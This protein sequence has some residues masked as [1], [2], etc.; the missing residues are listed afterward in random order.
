MKTARVLVLAL[1]CGLC[2]AFAAGCGS[3]SGGGGADDPAAVVPAGAV[4]YAEATIHPEGKVRADAEAA[5]RKILKTDDPAA[6]ITKA[7]ESASKG[8]GDL[9]FKDDVEPWL[10]DRVGA[11]VTSL[12]STNDADYVIV[13]ASKDDGKA[14][15]ALAKQK[16]DIVKRAYKGVDYRF[17]AKENTAA[18]VVNHRVVI[19]TEGGM[20]SAID[21]SKGDSLAEANGLRDVRAKVAP[22]RIGLFYLDVQGLLRTVA[23]S[24]SK[25]PALGAILQSA[26]GAAPRT[27]GGALQAQPDQ[28][29]VDAV[30]LATPKSSTTGG[31]G[32][33]VLAGLPADSWA[34]LGVANIGQTLDRIVQTIANTGGLTSVGVNA[35]LQQFQEKT[36]LDLRKD[37]LSW[38]GDAGVYVAGTTAH[39]LRGALVVKTT[40]AAKTRRTIAALERLARGSSGVHIRPLSGAGIDDG[41][42]IRQKSGPA[43][44]VALASDKLVVA[45]GPKRVIAEAAAPAQKLGSAPAF[46][47]AAAKLGG[48]L[49]PSFF[50][51]FPQ[52]VGLI[53]GFVGDSSPSFA[54]AKTYLDAF[55]TIVAGGKD[56]GDG[57]TRARFV[58]TLR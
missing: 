14:D 48:G 17:N 30:S 53:G 11:A 33:D 18:A 9:S 35:V 16:G 20:K 3:S 50:L 52:V 54:K 51:D 45:I 4:L 23:Q 2:A 15:D 24:A 27:I 38:M 28:L 7:L 46:T 41:F 10:G 34:G 25:D 43:V 39:D 29:R 6:K 32:A 56:E 57:V 55:G 47:A 22:D 40:D 36:G 49:R 26:S 58:V 13:L 42:T 8:E 19:G 12:R 1:L 44:H 37:V 21:A 5:L 31:S